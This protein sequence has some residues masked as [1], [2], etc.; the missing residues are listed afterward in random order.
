MLVFRISVLVMVFDMREHVLGFD[1]EVCY[2]GSMLIVVLCDVSW[3][4]R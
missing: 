2:L 4:C 3:D 1:A